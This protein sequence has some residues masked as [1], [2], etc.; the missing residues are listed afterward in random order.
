MARLEALAEQEDPELEV[1]V[2][3]VGPD[4]GRR[5]FLTAGARSSSGSVGAGRPELL[6]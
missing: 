3:T 4:G 6:E 5:G 2:V 1:R